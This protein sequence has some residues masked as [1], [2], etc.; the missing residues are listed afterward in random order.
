MVDDQ[1]MVYVILNKSSNKSKAILVD[2]TTK[3]K[4]DEIN[5]ITD[6]GN[7]VTYDPITEELVAAQ[8]GSLR[9]VKINK[10]A[11]KFGASREIRTPGRGC[12]SIAY[13]KQNDLF[14]LNNNVYTRQAFYTGGSPVRSIKEKKPSGKIYG[15]GCGSFGNHVYYA[16]STG[17]GEGP[18][19]L[20]VCNILTGQQEKIIKINRINGKIRE[21]E[22]CDFLSDGTLVCCYG[23]YGSGFFKTDYNYFADNDIDK[24]GVSATGTANTN[25]ISMYNTGGEETENSNFVRVLNSHRDARSNL[26]SVLSWLYDALESNED[27]K[28]MVDITKYLIG[29]AKGDDENREVFLAAMEKLAVYNMTQVGEGLGGLLSITSTTFTKEQFVQSVQSYSAALSKSGTEDFRNNAGVVYDVCVKNKINPVL[30]AAQAWKE[31]NWVYPST[32]KYNYWGIEVYNG[33]NYGRSFNTMEEAVEHYCKQIN[34]RLKG[35]HGAEKWSTINAKYNNKFTGGI[36]NLYDVLPNWACVD[37]ADNHPAEQAEHAANYVDSLVKCATQIFGEGA[38]TATGG[39]GDFVAV[40]ERIWKIICNGNYSY[41]GSSIPCTG[42]TV[43]CS[44]YVSWVIYEYGYSEFKGGQHCTSN[45][46]NTNWTQK[47]GWQEF[48]ISGGENPYNSLQPGD[49]IVRDPGNNNGHITLVVRKE[50]GKIYCYDC[51]SSK[52]WSGNPSGNALDKSYMLT[53]SRPGKVIRVKPKT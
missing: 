48:R 50:N 41:G 21:I 22:E 52:N 38:L 28:N 14:I 3:Q 23:T 2:L 18:D 9:V 5:G 35:E 25:S 36:N 7:S 49:L 12:R 30:C 8:W 45:F 40:A 17:Y 53:D 16:C 20:L 51:G 10:A 27:T 13:N 6:H 32:S 39:G 37:D 43:D 11:K 24:S 4:C 42:T 46:V 15:Q 34:E 29:R 26:L 47:Y 31:Q 1:F 33:Q 44:S 19:Y